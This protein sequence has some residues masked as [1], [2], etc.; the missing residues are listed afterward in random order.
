MCFPNFPI[1]QQHFNV[2]N[3]LFLI[4][5]E[6]IKWQ[7]R[8]KNKAVDQGSPVTHNTFDKPEGTPSWYL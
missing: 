5:R 4:F 6:Y 1:K 7:F 8:N 3:M 2:A